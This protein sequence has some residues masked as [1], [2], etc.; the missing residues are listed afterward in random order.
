MY[1]RAYKNAT[2]HTRTN[3]LKSRIL[4][5]FDMGVFHELM[6]ISYA[7]KKGG[8]WEGNGKILA[9]ETGSEPANRFLPIDMILYG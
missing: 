3:R 9:D 4:A 6:R 8:V 7:L 2:V 5:D 1:H